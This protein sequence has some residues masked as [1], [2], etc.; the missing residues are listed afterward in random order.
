MER[1]ETNVMAGP[2]A[3]PS[4]NRERTKISREGEKEEASWKTKRMEK[5]R[6]SV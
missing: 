3:R 4:K 5:E 6:R 1:K 2:T